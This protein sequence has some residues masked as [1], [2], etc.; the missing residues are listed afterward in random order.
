MPHSCENSVPH[1]AGWKRSTSGQHNMP[2]GV[3][4]LG[5]LQLQRLVQCCASRSLIVCGACGPV[6]MLASSH[7]YDSQ[8]AR[9]ECLKC[10]LCGS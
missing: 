4:L 9:L 5:I 1:Q 8:W 10:L 2:L 6:C 7:W 3:P